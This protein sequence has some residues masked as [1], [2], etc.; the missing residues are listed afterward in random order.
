M[1]QFGKGAGAQLGAGVRERAG[2]DHRPVGAAQ[3][4]EQLVEK[5]L[6]GLE[7]FLQQQ[8]HENG[9]SQDAS[10]REILR[11]SAMAGDQA[12]IG[13]RGAQLLDEVKSTLFKW[14]VVLHPQCKSR[15]YLLCTFKNITSSSWLKGS[16]VGVTAS[17]ITD[18]ILAITRRH[19]ADFFLAT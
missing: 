8:E 5:R 6:E 9:K 19:H 15:M 3:L 1:I 12:R 16:G 4:P 10:A 14:E 13:K 7:T 11:S 18:C 17:L 2:A